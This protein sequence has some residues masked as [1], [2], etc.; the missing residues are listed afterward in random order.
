MSGTTSRSCSSSSGGANKNHDARGGEANP[1]PPN[2]SFE[3]PSNVEGEQ[4]WV[5][6]GGVNSDSSSNADLPANGGADVQLGVKQAV[7]ASQKS[8]RSVREATA[9][10][11]PAVSSSI[12]ASSTLVEGG[13]FPL[14]FGSVSPALMQVPHP[15]SS[16]PPN[17]DNQKRDQALYNDYLRAAP[18]LRQLEGIL[19]KLTPQTF[20]RLFEQ[21]KQVN[22][23]NSGTLAGVIF[24]IHDR[25]LMKPAFC[26][27]YADFCYRLSRELP[28]FSENNEKITFKRLLINKC[29]EEFER[30][31][32]EQEEANRPE[33]EEAETKQSDEEGR[34]KRIQARR[35]KLGNIILIGELYKKKM[36]T[37]RI[38]HECIKKLL[39]QY[40]N[41]DEEDAEILCELM[42]TIGR[43]IDHPKAKV[44]M[45]AYFDKMAKLSNNMKLSSRV[46]FM[47][48]DLIDLRKNQWQQRW[49]AEGPK[50]IEKVHRE[51]A[52]ARQTQ[53]NWFTGRPS[54]GFS[55][56]R[57]QSIDYASGGS[58]ISHAAARGAY[59]AHSDLHGGVD[60]QVSV[61]PAIM[62][63]QN[64]TRGGPKVPA[65][66][67][68]AVSSSIMPPSTL[69]KGEGFP[70]QLGSTSSGSMQVGLRSVGKSVTA[71]TSSALPNL[72]EQKQEQARYDFVRAAHV[73]HRLE[74]I[75]NKLTPQNF[76]R[77]FEQVKQINIDN[78]GTLAGVMSLIYDKALMKPTL[79]GMFA[80]FCYHLSEELPDFIED[81][82]KITF[83]R[84][85]LNK[86]QEEF[87]RGEREREE[88][89]R[90]EEEGETQQSRKER[91]KKRIQAL[92]LKLGNIKLMGELYKKRMLTERIM[93]ECIK[94]LLGQYQNPDEQ[95]VEV[96]CKLM[97][98]IGEIIDHRK[99]KVHMDAYFDMMAKLSDNMKL[100][101]RVR[102]MLKDSID[103]R[104]NQWQ[105]RR[106]VEGPKKIEE[107]HREDT[108]ERQAQS[109]RLTRGHGSSMGSSYRRQ[110]PTDFAPTGA[111]RALPQ[112]QP[113]YDVQDFR[114]NE[115]P[116]SEK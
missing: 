32:S 77:L 48:T 8:T 103:L 21:V 86:C 39:I 94:K 44:H 3:K 106:K 19:D 10:N 110:Q 92:R 61:K 51:A 82:E 54:M 101:S 5:M 7:V 4:T 67:A 29:Q 38:M 2:T 85:L 80:N 96:L 56:R 70:L 78:A 95:D 23:D 45:D 114:Y 71:R 24:L 79:C 102:S 18:V 53:S 73:L 15:T 89:N 83:K 34:K 55:Y 87:E 50:K 60:A 116:P 30:G 57:Q 28:D 81:D 64:I 108:S 76:D 62:S 113:G 33:E 107:V 9:T 6:N 72:D 26:K 42:S 52:N 1:P 14:Q 31:E 58:S 75:L 105:Q 17:M 99:A 98:T 112:L 66:N 104:K 40:Q 69:V 68:S 35:R 109:I 88:T 20:D 100:S 25:A 90:P 91:E 12:M 84:L 36:L 59:G 22:I 74:G 97:S 46:R 63:S 11:V 115:R 41:P 43:M 16:T 37:E 93:H 111:F 47:L 49:K 65:V 27:I 13:G